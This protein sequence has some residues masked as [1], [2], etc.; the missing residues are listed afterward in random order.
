MAISDWIEKIGRTVFE[1]PFG[2]L[3]L[4]KDSPE[5]AEIRLAVLDEVKAKSH[6]VAGKD[7]FPYN[8]VRILI[9]GVPTEQ[10]P[11]FQGSFFSRFFQEEIKA[12]LTRS[13]YRFPEDLEIE[14][15]TAPGLPVAGEEWLVVVA[16]SRPKPA[17][18]AVR[19]GRVAKLV[20]LK[21]T[22]NKA[23]LPLAKART[24]IGRTID[25]YRA[26]GPSRRNDLAFTEETEINRTLSR[27]HAHIMLYKKSGEYRLFNDRWH[28]AGS[29]PD[30]ATNLWII[31]D[32][33]SQEVHHD[34]RG[35][36]L[37]PGDEI[38]FGRAVVLFK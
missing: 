3:Q 16:E 13:N 36:R 11:V 7:V 18:E 23:E 8:V 30:A 22:A 9:R 14:V 24:N 25:V 27:E 17:T 15:E 21:G 38:H 19:G 1:A 6:R 2:A 10:A 35:V 37:Q 4:T 12:G 33:L 29:K 5:L 31:R 34:A 20:V 28:K 26:D 32:G